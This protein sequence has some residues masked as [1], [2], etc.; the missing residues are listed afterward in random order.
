MVCQLVFPKIKLAVNF[1]FYLPT[2]RY[3][4]LAKEEGGTINCGYGANG[5][6]LNLPSHLQKGYFFPPTVVTNLPKGARCLR[7]EIFG[8]FVCISKF[9][10]ELEAIELANDVE[11]GLCAS[12]WS[13]NVGTIHRVSHELE[14]GTV[15]NNC[16]LIRSL[17]MPFGGCKQSGIGREG[18]THSLETYT[19]EKTVCIKIN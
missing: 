8:P 15:W 18:I 10:T 14:V 17:Q 9:S 6:S 4:K 7:E 11:Y 3:A 16:W 19:N 13:E 1:K 5:S 12:V 2:F